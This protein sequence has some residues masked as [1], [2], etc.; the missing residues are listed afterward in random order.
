MIEKELG[1]SFEVEPGAVLRLA[2]GDGTVAIRGWEHPKVQV[3]VRYRAEVET[4]KPDRL[5]DFEV[6]FEQRGREVLVAGREP[7]VMGSGTT[8]LRVHEYRY[9]V[10]A[11][12]WVALDLDGKDGGVS[13]ENWS[14]PVEL[15]SED[16]SFLID[17]LEAPSLSY[18]GEDGTLKLSRIR[19]PSVSV[20]FQD[21]SLD[22]ELL[23]AGSLDLRIRAEDAKMDVALDKS[24]TAA[25]SIERDEG[26]VQVAIPGVQQT[27]SDSRRYRGQIGDGRGGRIRIAMEDGKVLLRQ[28]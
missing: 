14:A 24:I 28:K 15:R 6:E 2:H 5:R 1:E 25:F 22:L 20:E 7:N 12:P 9:T 10:L 17:G 8:R 27:S 3:V 16:G 19:V 13:L 4:T 23:D 26:S 11:P 21:G 18:R